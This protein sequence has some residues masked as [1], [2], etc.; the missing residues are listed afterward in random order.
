MSRFIHV[1]AV[2]ILSLAPLVAIAQEEMTPERARLAACRVAYVYFERQFDQ[3]VKSTND[4]CQKLNYA[5]AVREKQISSLAT[6]RCGPV[7]G[8]LP[9]KL[10]IQLADF[11]R[12][13]S[14]ACRGPTRSTVARP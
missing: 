11:K 13:R 2:C 3:Q 12:M 9:V 10:R 14:E 5:V 6:P 1:F 8:D 7:L 4:R